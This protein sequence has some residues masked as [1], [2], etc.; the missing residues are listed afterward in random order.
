M[1]VTVNS[2]DEPLVK[3][4][5]EGSTLFIQPVSTLETSSTVALAKGGFSNVAVPEN[6]TFASC[7]SLVFT[8]ALTGER[9]SVSSGTMG[10]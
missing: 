10:D 1:T 7:H 3:T 6:V 4:M 2:C 9:V 5:V 8:V